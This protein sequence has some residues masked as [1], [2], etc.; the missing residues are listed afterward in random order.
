MIGALAI[1]AIAAWFY[2]TAERVD[3]PA[4]AW[5]IAGVLVYYGG[6]A[7]WMYLVLSP[8]LGDQFRNHGLWLGLGMDLSSVA[9]GVASA[10]AFRAFVMLK[11]GRPPF[12]QRF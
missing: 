4:L 12:E 5:C 8:V 1:L 6:F 2:R 7:F 9:V 10:A 3:L 11:K